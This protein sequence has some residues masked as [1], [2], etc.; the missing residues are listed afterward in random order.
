MT[1]ESRRAYMRQYMRQ[2]RAAGN[3]ATHVRVR[4]LPDDYRAQTARDLCDVL[5]EAIAD[6]R[7]DDTLTSTSRARTIA[8]VSGVMLR[9]IEQTAVLERLERVEAALAVQ[10]DSNHTQNGSDA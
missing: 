7:A 3:D 6:V 1:S 9:A 10:G 2:Y 5:A 8:T 4:L